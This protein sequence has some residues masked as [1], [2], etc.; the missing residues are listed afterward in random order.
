M[1]DLKVLAATASEVAAAANLRANN[2]Y[3]CLKER[4]VSEISIILHELFLPIACEGGRE[5][6]VDMSDLQRLLE[7]RF[8]VRDCPHLPY[9]KVVDSQ[10]GSIFLVRKGKWYLL[11]QDA[12]NRVYIDTTGLSTTVNPERFYYTW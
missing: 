8:H 9:T 5:G 12:A 3:K 1:V 10:D 7:K 4:V 2:S 11:I 6:K